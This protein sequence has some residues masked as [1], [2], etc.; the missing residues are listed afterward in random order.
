M[1]RAGEFANELALE[2]CFADFLHYSFLPETIKRQV[3]LPEG[4]ADVV[5]YGDENIVIELK[6]EIAKTKAVY[7]VESY[8]NYLNGFKKVLVAPSFSDDAIEL[9]KKLGVQCYEFSIHANCDSVFVH[10]ETK[11][12]AYDDKVIDGLDEALANDTYFNPNWLI[13]ENLDNHKHRMKNL[14][15]KYENIEQL[16]RTYI[17]NDANVKG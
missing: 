5:V 16:F 14:T 3:K 12:K 9:A 10:F 11:H 15:N 7:Q 2:E 8:E 4:R 1:I 13:Q 17:E 6:N